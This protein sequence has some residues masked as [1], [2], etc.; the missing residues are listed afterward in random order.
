MAY[1]PA[2][3]SNVLKTTAAVGLTRSAGSRRRRAASQQGLIVTGRFKPLPVT[4]SLSPRFCV[5]VFP[6]LND[7]IERD[8]H[9]VGKRRFDARVNLY[10]VN[11]SWARGGQNAEVIAFR[12]QR[13]ERA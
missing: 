8:A 5:Y 13:I 12:K 6:P 4:K 3:P 9:V 2:Q 11:W 7:P 1:W 10:E